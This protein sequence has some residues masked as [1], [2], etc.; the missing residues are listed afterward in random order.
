MRPRSAC[1]EGRAFECD[2]LRARCSIGYTQGQIQHLGVVF[3]R[4][5]TSYSLDLWPTY[6]PPGWLRIS[7]LV[8]LLTTGAVSSRLDTL[9]L[10]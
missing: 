7:V 4:E 2:F 6:M 8:C 5:F 9:L 3:A 1:S 10:T